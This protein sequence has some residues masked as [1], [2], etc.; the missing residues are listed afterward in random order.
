MVWPDSTMVC[1]GK[2]VFIPDYECYLHAGI[3][4]KILNVGKSINKKFASRYYKE[5]TSMAFILPKDSSD[6]V[7]YY[8]N[9]YACNFVSD[10]SVIC[11]DFIPIEKSDGIATKVCVNV[12]PLKDISVG[13]QIQILNVNYDILDEIIS[14]ASEANTL[15]TGDIVAFM[16]SERFNVNRDNL[17]KISI[18]NN[19][20]LENKLK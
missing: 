10:Y 14:S 5:F 8:R 12:E 1:S 17:L 13:K 4:V 7:S 20:T 2:P 6:A 18:N 15:K 9:P 16:M 3:G 19:I 11:G